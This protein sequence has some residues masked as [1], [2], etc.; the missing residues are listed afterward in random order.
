[1]TLY[2][3]SGSLPQHLYVW[4]RSSF[5]RND[6]TDKGA[7][8]PVVWF[9]LSSTPSRAWG[10]HVRTEDNAVVRNI[11]PHEIAFRPFTDKDDIWRN[12]SWDLH[13]AQ[14]WD[15]T[16]YQFALHEYTYLQNM[17][18]VYHTDPFANNDQLYGWYLFTAIPVGDG[19]SREPEQQKEY[20]FMRG[21]NGRLA[22]RPTNS[23]LVLDRSISTKPE[24]WP[25]NI[26]AQT[27]A[28]SV[29]R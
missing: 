16:G 9:G 2:T 21:C 17:E 28:W 3:H 12:R 19:W 15:C 27:K 5:L 7:Y 6:I 18:C 26:C 29:D 25:T 23:V 11:P 22:I 24:S 13:E 14:F 4:V 1:M 20:L 10:C 8:E